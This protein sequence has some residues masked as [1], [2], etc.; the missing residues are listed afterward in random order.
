MNQFGEIVDVRFPSLKYNTHR[1]FSYVQFRLASQAHAATGLDG[2][3]QGDNLKLLAK[4]SDPAHRKS[5]EGAMYEGREVFLA[6]LDWSA[7]EKDVKAAF[8]KYGYIENVRIPKKING[9][10]KGIGF[11]VFRDKEAATAALE[12]NLT[13]FR[14][15]KLNVAISTPDKTSRPNIVTSTATSQRASDS[16]APNH[17]NTRNDSINHAASP[18]STSSLPTKDKDTDPSAPRSAE[19]QSRTLALLNIPDTVNDTRI[20]ALCAPYGTLVRVQLR[21]THGGAILEYSDVASVGKASLALDG[22]EIAPGRL[23]S[24]G[25]V[26]DLN[27]ARGE[28]RSDRLADRTK[29]AKITNLQSAAPV[30]RPR[31]AESRRGG[32]GGLGVKKRN[33]NAKS[34]GTDGDVG[35]GGGEASNG[36]EGVDGEGEKQEEE[37]EEKKMV[38]KSNAD[39]REMMLK[40]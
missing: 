39:F 27:R 13:M 20:R 4:I 35:G 19:I 26:A 32:R 9:S 12:M 10:S 21:P 18:I 3:D 11:I 2:E 15:R 37:K 8:K 31:L 25:S 14:N 22:H 28:V 7:T 16:P 36:V 29:A 1:R 6:N 40:K 24:V 38:P 30:R 5:R 23:L 34:D 17:P 33:T